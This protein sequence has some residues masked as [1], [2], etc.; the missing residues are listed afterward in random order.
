MNRRIP[1]RTS[2][3]RLPPAG[4]ER[5][6]QK[7]IALEGGCNFREIG[8]YPSLDGRRLRPGRLFRSGVMAYLTPV[9]QQRL[10]QLGIRTIVDLRRADERRKEPTRWAD[11]SACVL[12]ADNL[13]DPPPMLRFTLRGAPTLPRMRQAMIGLYR[14]MPESLASRMG[15]MFERLVAGELPLLVHC[16]A[17]KDRT[18]FAVALI[19]EVLGI[20]REAVLQDYTFTNRA[21]DLERFIFEHRAG[22]AGLAQSSH[23]LM[24]VPS[25]VRNAL[26]TADPDY[27][28]AALEQLC[29][30]YGSA[31]GYV[32]R[33][34]GLTPQRLLDLRNLLLE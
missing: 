32:E 27:L 1:G 33:R 20:T 26:L 15:M 6:V 5:S 9:D 18:G 2:G 17:G 28:S 19:L 3:W 16:S 4:R 21:V 12:D 7:I 34:L 22:A 10:A 8:G 31:E 11:R 24:Q 25:D 13:Q 23:P 29:S 30:D 14:D